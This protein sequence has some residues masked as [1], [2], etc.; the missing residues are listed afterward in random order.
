MTKPLKFISGPSLIGI[1]KQ[2]SNTRRD[3]SLLVAAQV[4][5]RI[6]FAIVLCG[7]PTFSING[8]SVS[9]VIAAVIFNQSL[10]LL[11]FGGWPVW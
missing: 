11:S 10:L 8:V 2:R 3:I 1:K 5:L 9:N 4:I 6:L 7:V